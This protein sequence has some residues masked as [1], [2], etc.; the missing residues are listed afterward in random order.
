MAERMIAVERAGPVARVRL[1][2]PPANAMNLALVEEATSVWRALAAEAEPPALLITGEGRFF[3]AGVDL[4]EVPAYGPEEQRRLLAAINRCFHLLYGYARPVVAAVNGHALGG[5]L[6]LALA[7]D[8]RV[9]TSAPCKLGLREVRVGVPFPVGALEVVRSALTP[10]AA[11]RIALT[12]RDLDP[13]EALA[14]GAVDEI[15]PAESVLARATELATEMATL[16]PRAYA[17]TKR[18]LRRE[19]LERMAEASDADRDPLLGSWLAPESA[20][21]AREVL[22]RPRSGRES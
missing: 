5:G 9:A 20:S 12:A 19:S 14:E 17:I 21:S 7:A 2:R 3:S 13:A 8:Y 11:R 18:A 6:I 22:D 16:P 10:A 15:R 4:K 1:S